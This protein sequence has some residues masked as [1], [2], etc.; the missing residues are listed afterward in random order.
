MFLSLFRKLPNFHE[1]FG[2]FLKLVLFVVSKLDLCWTLTM[3]FFLVV[4][5]Y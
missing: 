2:N 5:R 4:F 1:K 3:P